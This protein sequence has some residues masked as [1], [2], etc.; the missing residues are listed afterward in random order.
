MITTYFFRVAFLVNG[1]PSF[2]VVSED[3]PIKTVIQVKYTLKIFATIVQASHTGAV[4]D[5]Q[6][7]RGS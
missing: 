7:E 5:E 1:T 4:R 3:T 6:N 2:R